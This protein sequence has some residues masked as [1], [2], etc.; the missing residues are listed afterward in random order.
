MSYI[1]HNDE[2]DYW[3]DIDNFSYPESDDHEVIETPEYN[4][5][6]KSPLF[7]ENLDILDQKIRRKKYMK[8]VNKFQG[9]KLANIKYAYIPVKDIK[10]L[11]NNNKYVLTG[12]KS[13]TSS[14]MSMYLINDVVNFDDIKDGIT[15]DWDYLGIYLHAG[16]DG[17]DK[18]NEKKIIEIRLGILS[19]EQKLYW[20]ANN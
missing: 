9:G 18:N 16:L 1:L 14:G 17:R 19:N 12:Y 3:M 7:A 5:L 6:A 20:E 13:A 10:L 4:Y 11:L 2:K 8:V 15:E